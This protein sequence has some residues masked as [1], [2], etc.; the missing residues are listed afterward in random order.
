MVSPVVSK[1]LRGG[2]APPPDAS[3]LSKRADAINCYGL[4]I[5]V[6]NQLDLQ[7]FIWKD[8]MKFPPHI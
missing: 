3:S 4:K 5:C 1:I 8:F 2:T 7:Y 6:E